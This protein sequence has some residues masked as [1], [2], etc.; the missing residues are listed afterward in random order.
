MKP[1]HCTEKGDAQRCERGLF[2]DLDIIKHKKQPMTEEKTSVIG[3]FSY[4]T[5]EI[6]KKFIDAKKKMCYNDSLN[7]GNIAKHT[8]PPS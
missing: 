7:C 6:L 4:K 8:F 3:D 1:S 2:E 5:G